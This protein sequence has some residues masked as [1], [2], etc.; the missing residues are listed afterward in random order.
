LTAWD[1]PLDAEE[2]FAAYARRIT[3]RYVDAKQLK[4]TDERFE[5][6]TSSGVVAME[7]RGSRVA[8]FEGIPSSTN[9]NALLRAI[10]RER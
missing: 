2:F 7:L 9:A 5:W 10:W 3:K 6:Q 1:T 8:I 4:T